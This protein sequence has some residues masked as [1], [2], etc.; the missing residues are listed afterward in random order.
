MNSGN[1]L[2]GNNTS[3]AAGGNGAD[4]AVAIV[5]TDITLLR[6]DVAHAVSQAKHHVTDDINMLVTAAGSLGRD[7]LNDAAQRVSAF[8]SHVSATACD[9]TRIG[10]EQAQRATQTTGTFVKQNPWQSLAVALAL[11]YVFARLTARR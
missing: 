11:G 9:A 8:M 4:G 6:R 10:K 2:S 1:S 7:E 5:V 3:P